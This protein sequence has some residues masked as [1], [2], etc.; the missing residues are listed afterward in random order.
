MD[1]WNKKRE[2]NMEKTTN[3]RAKWK[4]LASVQTAVHSEFFHLESCA[5]ATQCSVST[6][7]PCTM[8]Q[9]RHIHY[10]SDRSMYIQLVTRVSGRMYDSKNCMQESCIYCCWLLFWM[11]S[12]YNEIYSARRSF[13]AHLYPSTTKDLWGRKPFF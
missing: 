4:A 1:D 13:C 5:D 12:T 8:P 3:R 10:H 2:K 6:R 9:H 7:C 11:V